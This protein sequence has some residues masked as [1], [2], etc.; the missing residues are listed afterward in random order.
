MYAHTVI[1]FFWTRQIVLLNRQSADML[2]DIVKDTIDAAV[3]Q[4]SGGWVGGRRTGSG[5]G[6][7]AVT[8]KVGGY[9]LVLDYN[10]PDRFFET[11]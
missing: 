1:Q 8:T 11:V 4:D 6:N 9:H 5:C 7:S 3:V 2:Q 10:G